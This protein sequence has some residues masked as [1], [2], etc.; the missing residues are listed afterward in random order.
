[1]KLVKNNSGVVPLV[2]AIFLGV[3]LSIVSIAFIRLAI[4]ERRQATDD[5]LTTAAF[6]AA[7]SGLEDAKR[8]LGQYFTDTAYGENELKGGECTPAEGSS[9][10][11]ADASTLDS[12]YTCQLIDLTPNFLVAKPGEGNSHLFKL[13]TVN[14]TSNVRQAK[15]RIEIQW[16]DKDTDGARSPRSVG[17]TSTPEFGDW[18]HPA[19]L[20]VNIFAVRASGSGGLNI[21]LDD[22]R[23]TA[24]SFTAF[25]NP[26][27]S[28][29]TTHNL[30]LSEFDAELLPGGCDNG[31]NAFTCKTT[32]NL[33]ATGIPARYRSVGWVTYMEVQTLYT[34][35]T[36]RVDAYSNSSGQLSFRDS[37][38]KI[39]VTGRSGDAFRR[40][41]TFLPLEG[42]SD[43]GL[44]EYTVIGGDRI[45]KNFNV[46]DDVADTATLNPGIGST[47]CS[48]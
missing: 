26:V 22:L 31:D 28:T 15:Q 46:T 27:D 13:D 34:S 37:Q 2:T 1:M 48:N 3:L 24:E 47:S 18:D 40:I 33:N 11:L 32:I 23:G 20:R 17:D 36:V 30:T 38:A 29:P 43:L 45:C 6:Y 19:M 14:S 41:E 44:P 9:P 5:D 10:D 25:I 8:V 42:S 4:S 35:D 12:S 21:D 16:N 39:D 7:E